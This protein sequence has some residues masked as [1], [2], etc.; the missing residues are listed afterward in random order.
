[1]L[2]K[3]TVFD[4]FASPGAA[5]PPFPLRLSPCIPALY[6]PL[7]AAPRLALPLFGCPVRAGFPSPATDYVS[8]HLDLN[9][10]LIAHKE[11]TFFVRAKGQ[12]ML[13]AG[14]QDGDLLIV[15]RSR[16]DIDHIVKTLRGDDY[17]LELIC[18]DQAEEARSAIDYQPLDLILLRLADD[19]PALAQIRL[20]VTE[21]AE[22]LRESDRH[23]LRR[24]LAD[25]VRH[26]GL[27]KPN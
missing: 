13:G 16:S 15:D 7:P 25:M 24:A 5:M 23:I 18:T 26:A 22:R 1:M 9:E 12:S 10:H 21:A 27:R 8:D 2:Y 3:I 11:A 20:M 19:L 17:Q 6:R 14:I 4:I